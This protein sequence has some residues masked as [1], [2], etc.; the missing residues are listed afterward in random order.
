MSFQMNTNCGAT[1]HFPSDLSLRTFAFM[2][3]TP[4]RVMATEE[5]A[6]IKT[7]S[8]MFA[9]LQE[10]CRILIW[11]NRADYNADTLEAC[12]NAIVAEIVRRDA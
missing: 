5:G 3:Y 9:A 6:E 12:T 10:G 4:E 11:A 8:E 1:Y 7:E 2:T